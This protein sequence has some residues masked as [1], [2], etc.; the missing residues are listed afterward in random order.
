VTTIVDVT[1]RDTTS[2]ALQFA[3]PT[4]LDAMKTVAARTGRKLVEE[5]N[6]RR[7]SGLGYAVDSTEIMKF[8]NVPA[9][10]GTFPGVSV[11][12]RRPN[13]TISMP[14]GGGRCV[15]EI[16]IDGIEAG[17]GH[18]A[19]LFTH[20]VAAVE[21]YNRALIAPAQFS[22]PGHPPECGMILVWSKY[23]FRNR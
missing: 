23:G 9:L 13:Y 19:D 21:V 4:T 14:A 15:P 1:A 18:I 22:R 17:F 12:Y 7:K 16:Y 11:E 2:L 6:L 8:Q 5:F 10:L 20:E 3:A